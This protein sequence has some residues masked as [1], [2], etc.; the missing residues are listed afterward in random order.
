MEQKGARSYLRGSVLLCVAECGENALWGAWRGDMRTYLY[1]FGI[2]GCLWALGVLF[3]RRICL[4]W[5]P[6]FPKWAWLWP[7]GLYGKSRLWLDSGWWF[8]L[9]Y[10]G[11][12]GG[13][14][15]SGAAIWCCYLGGCVLDHWAL[16]SAPLEQ[17][18]SLSMIHPTPNG[19]PGAALGWTILFTA[20][21]C[22]CTAFFWEDY[23]S[24]EILIF[25]SLSISSMSSE[26]SSSLIVSSPRFLV[27][28]ASKLS[29]Y[30]FLFG[31]AMLIGL[32]SPNFRSWFE[33]LLIV[34]LW[35]IDAG[36]EPIVY[37]LPAASCFVPKARCYVSTCEY[38]WVCPYRFWIYMIWA[39]LL[40][41]ASVAFVWLLAIAFLSGVTKT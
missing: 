37:V 20:L 35:V 23:W 38:M 34:G 11:L 22:D 5:L 26:S 8:R 21:A 3:G 30:S 40:W 28:A 29:L 4:C 16:D 6:S 41:F 33:G 14:L 18:H 27:A 19:L 17:L 12:I 32:G 15:I 24:W 13:G 31:L 2:C 36:G 1:V 9:C 25:V 39:W 7:G 10:L